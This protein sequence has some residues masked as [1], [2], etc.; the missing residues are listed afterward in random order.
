[1]AS[2]YYLISSLPSLKTDSAMPLSYA[3]FLE[4]CKSSVGKQVYENLSSLT[5]LSDEGSFLSKWSS[6]NKKFVEELNYQRKVKLGK[7]VDSNHNVDGEILKQVDS[8]L[9][10][11]NPLEAEQIMLGYQFD[12]LDSLVSMHYFDEYV[13]YGY[14]LKLKLL[15]RQSSFVKEEGSAEFK[16]LF[17]NIQQQILGI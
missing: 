8:V 16:R 15:E 13:L 14:A 1:M 10:A 6:F 11:K 4:M 17:D 2:Y 7:K 12:Y 5:T 9:S 3:S